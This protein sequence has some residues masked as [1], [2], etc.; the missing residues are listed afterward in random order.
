MKTTIIITLLLSR[1]NTATAAD[2]DLF[3]APFRAGIGQM[4]GDRR[5]AGF[6]V[7][8]ARKGALAQN[9][10]L[11]I[12]QYGLRLSR[13]SNTEIACRTRSLPGARCD[14]RR[15]SQTCAGDSNA[16]QAV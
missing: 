16:E 11:A 2:R 13:A 14:W 9:E 12:R 7:L 6:K 8:I 5:A 4:A 1:W 3:Q 15:E 10:I